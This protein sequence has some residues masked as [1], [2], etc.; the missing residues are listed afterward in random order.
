MKTFIAIL[1]GLLI[2]ALYYVVFPIYIMG[3]I[4]WLWLPI[5]FDTSNCF[6]GVGLGFALGIIISVTT[7]I[8]SQK[9]IEKVTNKIKDT[10]I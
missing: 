5:V 2:V 6:G 10:N 3:C 7:E 4:A 1:L 8:I 9:V